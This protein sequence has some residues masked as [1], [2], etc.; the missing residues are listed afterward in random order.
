MN[1]LDTLTALQ[2]QGIGLLEAIRGLS[3]TELATYGLRGTTAGSWLRLSDIFFGPTRERRTQSR[4]VA[5]AR[6]GELSVEALLVIE[7]HVRKLLDGDGWALRAELCQLRG[8]VDEI[9]RAA[10]ARVRDLNRTVKDSERRA[11]GRRALRGGKNTDAQGLRTI[12]LTLPERLMARAL[13]VLRTRARQLRANDP[14]LSY[15]QAMADAF[16]S[17]LHG[18]EQHTGRESLTPLVVVGVPDWAKLLRGEGGEC[19]FALTDGTTITGAELIE[20]SLAEHHLVGLYDPVAGPV[21]LYRSRRQA[22]LKQRLLLAAET[23]L[24]PWPGCTTSADESQVHH[25]QAWRRAGQTNLDNLSMACP[26]H[27]G[28]NDDDPNAPP[29]HGRLAREKGHIVHHPPGGGQPQVNTHPI[30]KL[31]AR[32]LLDDA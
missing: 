17:H 26:V 28:R 27:N 16:L 23:I 20:R 4:A 1:L 13:T 22:T 14:R 10:A 7:K 15:E 6:E 5:A 11:Y 32:G 3:R 18:R 12:T 2:T 8:S 30:R 29:R 21:N 31:S 19:V 24:C 25:L 9:D